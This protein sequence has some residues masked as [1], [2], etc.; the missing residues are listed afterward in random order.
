MIATLPLLLLAAASTAVEWL[1]EGVSHAQ[2]GD[3][4]LAEPAFAQACR[5]EPALP[6]ACFF[7]GRAL[8]FLDRYEDA[9][10]PL[11]R[12]LPA[13][14]GGG[15]ARVHT[16]IAQSLEAL[17]RA[18]EAEA[19]FAQALAAR[20]RLAE[21]RVKYGLFLLRQ[22]RTTEAVAPLRDALQIDAAQPE[23]CLELGR[24]LYQLDRLGE[25]LPHL[26]R[27]AELNPKSAQAHA[28]LAR[29]YRRLGRVPEADRHLAAARS[30]N[31]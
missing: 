7:L 6:D 23:G 24:A 21:P 4:L 9:L 1:A 25:A 8:Y 10:A 2:R 20:P 18:S 26:R 17:G 5:L 28:L 11:R 30:L 3:Y 15:A 31:P 16:A 22:G 14:G 29:V 13:A 27:A 12:S 19:S